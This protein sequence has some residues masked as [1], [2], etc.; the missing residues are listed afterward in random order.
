MIAVSYLRHVRFSEREQAVTLQQSKIT[1]TRFNDSWPEFVADFLQTAVYPKPSSNKFECYGWTPTLFEEGLNKY[2]QNGHWRLAAYGGDELSLFV[3]DL[4][5]H[6]AGRSMIDIDALEAFLRH[7]GLSFVLYTSFT[8]TPEKHKVR[9]V[10]PVT[11]YLTPDEAFRVGLWFNAALDYQLDGAIYDQADYLYGPPLGSD[12]RTNVTGAA[13]DVDHYLT[14]TEGL[15]EEARGSWKR[16]EGNNGATITPEQYAH[17][18]KMAAMEEPS[19]DDVS[20]HNPAIFAPRWL[21]LLSSL[22]QGGSRSRTLRGLCAK[23]WVR[24][25]GSLTKGDLWTLYREMD[26]TLGGYCVRKYGFRECDRD[27]R[28][29]MEAVGSSIEFNDNW[30]QKQAALKAAFGRLRAK[31]KKKK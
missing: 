3:A 2:G 31:R 11:R 4:D 29:A 20:I 5:N 8:H 19:R 12:I 13:L 14:L 7:L 10:T 27:I 9:V 30:K 6:T 16:G 24:S 15:D 25:Q 17:A 28:S 1:E 26:A 21:T 22:Y 23:A 18:M